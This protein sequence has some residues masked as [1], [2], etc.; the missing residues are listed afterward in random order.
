M[1][2]TYNAD[3]KAKPQYFSTL[4]THVTPKKE[5][6]PT[7]LIQP[8]RTFVVPSAR[9]SFSHQDLSDLRAQLLHLRRVDMFGLQQGAYEV[10]DAIFLIFDRIS[11]VTSN[12]VYDIQ[13]EIREDILDEIDCCCCHLLL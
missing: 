9:T 6:Y 11:Q 10:L 3:R 2:T 5:P 4:A 7:D 8:S 13:I 12:V 1:S